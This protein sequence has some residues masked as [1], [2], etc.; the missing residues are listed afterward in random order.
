MTCW[1]GWSRE[2]RP[3]CRSQS[4]ARPTQRLHMSAA[5]RAE[6]AA[7]RALADVFQAYLRGSPEP[8]QAQL[9]RRLGDST[10]EIIYGLAHA[11]RA[12]G[13]PAGTIEV[14]VKLRQRGQH[15]KSGPERIAYP[16]RRDRGRRVPLPG[17]GRAR[18]Q[19]AKR[20]R[21]RSCQVGARAGGRCR[22]V[23]VMRE[24]NSMSITQP[25]FAE[26]SD[27]MPVLFV[28]HG[29]PT[30]VIEDNEFSRAWAEIGRCCPGRRRSSASRRTGKRVGTH[31]TAMRPPGRS[32]TFTA[33]P[34]SFTGRNTLRQARRNWRGLVQATAPIPVGLDQSWGLDHGGGRS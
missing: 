26:S 18:D 7:S 11:L 31:V 1:P 20:P 3:Q 28:G 21:G 30:N 2:A 32:M 10:Q 6:L 12:A 29:S 17:P 27:R 13:E 4:A 22:S 5:L 33:S 25:S 24:E 19:P 14:D 15:Q 23:L 9:Y 16:P 8:K 34:M